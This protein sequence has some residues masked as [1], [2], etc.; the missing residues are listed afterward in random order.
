L[1]RADKLFSQN[2][3]EMRFHYSEDNLLY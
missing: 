1:T 3:A 2:T